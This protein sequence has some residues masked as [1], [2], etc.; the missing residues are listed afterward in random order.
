MPT[1]DPVSSSSL[2]LVSDETIERSR[3]SAATSLTKLYGLS[4]LAGSVARFDPATGEKRKL[5]KSYKNQIADLA[6]KH[7]IPTSTSGSGFSLLDLARMP[8]KSGSTSLVP[9]LD[10]KQLSYALSLDKTPATGIPDFDI[11]MLASPNFLH[12]QQVQQQPNQ[13]P[14]NLKS[15]NFRNGLAPLTAGESSNDDSTNAAAR[16]LMKKKKRMTSDELS[17]DDVKRRKR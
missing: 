5:R 11:A 13:Q 2:Y 1:P 16:R 17:S 8:P 9:P 15:K 4:D 3:P 12:Q 14:Q 10:D 6:G 7:V